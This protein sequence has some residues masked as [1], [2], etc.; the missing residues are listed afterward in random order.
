MPSQFDTH[1]GHVY[2]NQKIFCTFQIDQGFI[3]IG[4]ASFASKTPNIAATL[5]KKLPPIP[6]DS[7]LFNGSYSNPAL[8]FCKNLG[9]SNIAFFANGGFANE[10]GETDIC[11]FGDGSMVSGWS[12]IYIANNRPGYDIVREK[13]RAESLDID[14]PA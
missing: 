13:T 12:L 6:P 9:G 10:L 7:P 5:I 1:S 4:L 14:I 11:V 3:A 8:N 2:G